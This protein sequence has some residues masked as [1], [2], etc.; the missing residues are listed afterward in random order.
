[1]S[2]L[3]FKL[4]EFEGPLDLLLFLVTKNKLNINDIEISLLLDQYLMYI[5]GIEETDLEQAGEFLAMAARLI[6]IKTVSLLPTYAEAIA[7]K[8]ELE[9]RLIEYSLCKKAAALLR[10]KYV[11]DS[12]FVRKQVEV[13]VDRT[14]N[15]LH[16]PEDL[17]LSFKD[18]EA[19]SELNKPLSTKDFRPLVSKK[20][21]SVTAK[22]FYVLKTLYSG[23]IFDMTKL[24]F[25][26]AEKSERIATFL[27][28]LE[29]T[30]SGRIML[31]EDNSKLWFEK[32]KK[33]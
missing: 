2:Q 30:K 17:V 5:E 19:K 20:V 12:I 24:Y 21:Y 27:A 7:L 16:N 29:L 18:F 26:I 32:G 3:S 15:R 31:N 13:E 8:K 10:E 22:I 9:G 4:N 14:Y 6:Y 1:M 23:E 33:V 28:I 11:G 25:G